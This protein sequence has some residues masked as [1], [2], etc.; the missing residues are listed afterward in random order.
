MTER[1]ARRVERSE[2]ALRIG[3][4][5]LRWDGTTLTLDIEEVG[6]PLPRRIV[7]R[8]RVHADAWLADSIP[9]DAAARHMWRP[10]APCARVEVAMTH[11]ASRWQGSGYLDM[12]HGTSGLEH[13]FARWHWSRARTGAGSATVL[14]DV[15]RRDGSAVSLALRF[16]PDGS[17]AG[18]IEPPPL[19]AL[20]RSA[21]RV[22]R[23]TRADDGAAA[24]R[25]TL[26]DGP[27]YARSLLDVAIGGERVA[28][29]HE[30]LDLDRFASPWVQAMLPF[31][32]PRRG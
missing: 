18:P 15:T 17:A 16:R 12:N 25:A 19:R 3:P 31:R 7:G 20:P 32:M 30:S 21:W 26:E 8:I 6:A 28:A 13:D 2:T 4:S 22:A 11:P 1:G 23:S 14:Y 29:V 27:F 10:I 5:A 24:V 9:L